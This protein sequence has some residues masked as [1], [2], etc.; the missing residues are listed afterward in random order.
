MAAW[1]RVGIPAVLTVVFAIPLVVIIRNPT[2]REE[3]MVVLILSMTAILVIFSL[4]FGVISVVDLLTENDTPSLLC[5]LLST[6]G[7]SL[8]VGFKLST[9]FLAVEQY[10]AVIFPLQHYVTMS[11][12]ANKMVVFTWLFI[13]ALATFG[14]ACFQ[15][16]L[17]TTIE[18]DIRVFDTE[19]ATCE[20]GWRDLT[21]A[22]MVT[23]MIF[24]NGFSILN[25]VLLL[26]TAVQGLK[27]E[28]RIAEGEADRDQK[29]LV[30]FKS[31]K[32]I[33]KLL[34]TFLIIDI[35]GTV[36]HIVSRGLLM[37]P[38]LLFGTHL[39]RVMSLLVEYWAYGFSNTI[40]PKALK[41]FFGFRQNQAEPQ[42]PVG[43]EQNRP[44]HQAH[45]EDAAPSRRVLEAPLALDDIERSE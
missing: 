12:W 20:C 14:V 31:F 15:A 44:D 45:A 26:Y 38:Q 39:L 13:A 1:L 41:A 24:F 35:I 4:D 42:G 5:S 18:F 17:E 10:V 40:I 6:F 22:H 28:R 21:V 16:G 7:L 32:R 23:S 37:P 11:G 33:I 30:R 34:L 43:V 3:P 27:H 9:V 8:L 25:C 36:F 29:F 2:I 19:T